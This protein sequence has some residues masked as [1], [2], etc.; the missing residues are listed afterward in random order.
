MTILGS[1]STYSFVTSSDSRYPDSINRRSRGELASIPEKFSL[2]ADPRLWGHDLS[3][4]LI[5]ADDDLHRPDPESEARKIEF[6]GHA[7][8]ERGLTNVGCLALLCLGVLT[9]FLGYPVATF[10]TRS[11]LSTF[12]GFST[13]GLNA[14]GQVPE[15]PGNWGLIDLDTPKDVYTKPGWKDSSKKMQLVFSDEFNKDGRSFYPGD[16]PYWEA[17]DLH[18]WQTNNLEWYDPAA[19][20]TASGNLVITLSRKKTH[21][22]NYQGGL[23]STWNKFC[24]TGGLIETSVVIPGA[25]NVLGLWPAIWAMGNLGRA[26]YGASLEGTWPYTYDACDVGTVKNQ[27]V[28]G[29][30]TAATVDGDRGKGGVLSYLPGQKLSRCTCPGESHPGPKHSDGTFVGRSAPEIDVFE[31][32]INKATLIPAVSQSAQWAPYNKAYVWNNDTDN[33]FIRDPSN[34]IQNSFT[35]NVNQQATSVVTNTNPQC[36]EDS[37]DPCYSVYGFEYKPGF[38]DAYILWISD[39]E[40]SWSLNVAGLDADPKVEISARP[41]SQEPMYL[42]MNLGMSRNFGP[43]DL[44]HL[45]FPAHM[46][47]DWIRVYQDSD[48]INIGCD[49]NKFPTAN[50]INTYIEA[51]TNPNLT[52]WVD[53]YGQP[54]PKNSF[55]GEC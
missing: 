16:D 34:S 43:V 52:T 54:F 44:A 32:Q 10:A 8:S 38:D 19:V 39:N 48:N 36:Y 28:N 4:N 40:I 29:Q 7:V 31:A 47:V 33:M 22:L 45:Q 18:Y 42:L 6:G 23:I 35:G 55:L 30:P 24:F 2:N 14:S 15:I 49:P 26:G 50:Y 11:P 51:Y 37:I 17:V 12:G 46:Y 25:N 5:E 13:G 21:D 27:T 1:Q 3:P 41:V 9:L 53:D 20:T